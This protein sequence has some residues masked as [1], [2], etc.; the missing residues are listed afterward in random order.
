MEKFGAKITVKGEKGKER[1]VLDENATTLDDTH[2][3]LEDRRETKPF[4]E[5]YNERTSLCLFSR[6]RIKE[7]IPKKSSSAHVLLAETVNYWLKVNDNLARYVDHHVKLSDIT[8]EEVRISKIE[9]FRKD[10]RRNARLMRTPSSA[11]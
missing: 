11:S 8:D 2:K 3:L 4:F 7:F 10:G 5:M 1:K 9:S 6:D